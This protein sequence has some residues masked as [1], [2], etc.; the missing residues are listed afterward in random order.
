MVD[1]AKLN[2][3]DSGASLRSRIFK[4]AAERKIQIFL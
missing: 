3:H 4:M 2:S 1:G